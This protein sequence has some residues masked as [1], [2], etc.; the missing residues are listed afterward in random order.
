MAGPNPGFAICGRLYVLMLALAA[1]GASIL[2]A[3]SCQ[4][5]SY[6][7]T[8]AAL[9]ERFGPPFDALTTASVGL[10]SYSAATT[11][12]EDVLFGDQCTKYEDWQDVGQ[13][14]YFAVAQWCGIAAPIVDDSFNK[15]SFELGAWYSL[16]AAIVY[17]LLAIIAPIV[18]ISPYQ[19]RRGCCFVKG[20]PPKKGE[21]SSRSVA[22]SRGHEKEAGKREA[23]V[24]AMEDFDFESAAGESTDDDERTTNTNNEGA[25]TVTEEEKAAQ[26]KGGFCGNDCFFDNICGRKEDTTET[27]KVK[28]GNE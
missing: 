17:L 23:D 11:N 18:P 15:C 24:E 10:F 25:A 16:G 6:R 9:W 1:I 13:S 26:E 27:K 4:M 22:S 3:F 5:F 28:D 7:T 12:D 8:D 21:A 20:G 2:L 19:Q 14:S